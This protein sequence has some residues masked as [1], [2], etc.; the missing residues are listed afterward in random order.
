MT[1]IA[2]CRREEMAGRFAFSGGAVVAADA[3][4]VE[5]RVIDPST[6]KGHA[7]PVASLTWSIGDD[8]IRAF[9][10]RGN[11]V[12]AGCTAAHETGVIW[13]C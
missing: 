9:A 8:V 6:L 5:A 1:R 13:F 2:G 7:T 4:T 12:V 3:C 11:A 10:S